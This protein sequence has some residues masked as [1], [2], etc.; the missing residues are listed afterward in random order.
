MK[1]RCSMCSMHQ[2]VEVMP[3]LWKRDQTLTQSQR[4]TNKFTEAA[5]PTCLQMA[6]EAFQ[7]QFP[8]LYTSS[9]PLTRK[10]A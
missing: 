10:S 2:V 4:S 9:A 5:C 8:A 3:G 1:T 6:R 7:Q